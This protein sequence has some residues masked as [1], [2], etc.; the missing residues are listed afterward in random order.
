MPLGIRGNGTRLLSLCARARNFA[1]ITKRE[2][3]PWGTNSVGD[4]RKLLLDGLTAGLAE[5]YA[6]RVM[7]AFLMTLDITLA[8]ANSLYNSDGD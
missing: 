2:T 6:Q 1:M 3:A 7:L 5:Q 4:N 8:D